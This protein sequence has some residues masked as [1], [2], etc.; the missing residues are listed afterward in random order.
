[1]NKERQIELMKQ[2]L[3][4]GRDTKMIRHWKG[5]IDKYL[6]KKHMTPMDWEQFYLAKKYLK[7]AEETPYYG[8]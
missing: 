3:I 8:N 2:Y 1:M 7:D 5:V 6:R 4:A